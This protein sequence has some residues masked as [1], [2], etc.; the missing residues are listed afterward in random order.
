MNKKMCIAGRLHDGTAEL[1]D[2][3]GKKVRLEADLPMGCIGILF[4]FESK[5]AA[6]EHYKDLKNENIMHI[7]RC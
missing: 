5:K 1:E 3:F 6:K 2:V 4:A 7:K